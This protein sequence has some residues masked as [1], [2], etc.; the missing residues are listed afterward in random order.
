VKKSLVVL[1]L[2]LS[3]AQAGWGMTLQQVGGE[4]YA[5]V[6]T[7]H[8]GDLHAGSAAG[9]GETASKG[10]STHDIAG[11][12]EDL[13]D[14]TTGVGAYAYAGGRTF[15]APPNDQTAFL[16]STTAQGKHDPTIPNPA[17]NITYATVR[18]GP[19]PGDMLEFVVS[20]DTTVGEYNDQDVELKVTTN[21]AGTLNST[22]YPL[23]GLE[24]GTAAL[25]FVFQVYTDPTADPVVSFEYNHALTKETQT[26]PFDSEDSTALPGGLPTPEGEL[27]AVYD[28][29]QAGDHI[30]VYF[31][32]T[33]TA[34]LPASQ[35]A[36]AK[37]FAQ[38]RMD[39]TAV[40]ISVYP[41]ADSDG[42]P[43]SVDNCAVIANSDQSDR[44]DDGVGD[45][46]D[47]CPDVV[48]SNQE[49]G[50]GDGTGDACDNTPPVADAGPDKIMECSAPAGARVV[51]DG[52]GSSDPDD[53]VLTYTWQGPFGAVNGPRRRV[54]LP[55]GLHMVTLSVN[56]GKGGVD[57][58]TASITVQDT[59]PP[60]LS[61]AFVSAGRWW[62]PR[63]QLR[64][65]DACDPNP[66]VNNGTRLRGASC[67]DAS[68]NVGKLSRRSYWR[69][70]RQF[71]SSK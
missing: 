39:A 37:A 11:A 65:S 5:E 33:V 4:I 52:T 8:F 60:R 40:A 1:T 18:S 45:L 12:P 27:E 24:A 43:D 26:S 29:L 61:A 54:R 51:L 31:E 2:C 62:H 15:R 14:D 17:A 69:A 66:T 59:T 55:L 44:D 67:Q 36:A 48:N 42:V 38:S 57:S 32:Q 7:T 28:K 46:C 71:L 10:I 23:S 41:D 20:P 19:N 3:L 21:L 47:N 13:F 49:D 22:G 25:D 68:G 30:W 70:I 56:D 58:D 50:D 63:L 16:L 35:A 53:D 9:S 64:C 34:E 6:A